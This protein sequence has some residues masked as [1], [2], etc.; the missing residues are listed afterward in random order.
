MVVGLFL[1]SHGL[2]AFVDTEIET[3]RHTPLC[4]RVRTGSVVVPI[5]QKETAALKIK[6]A[7]SMARENVSALRRLF[8]FAVVRQ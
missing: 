5:E 4:R 6:A 7:V 3:W 1:I 2:S 8:F